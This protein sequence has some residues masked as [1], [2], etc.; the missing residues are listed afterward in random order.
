MR[1]TNLENV[2]SV[3]EARVANSKN[4]HQLVIL[5]MERSGPDSSNLWD[6]ND[7]KEILEALEP[8]HV[9]LRHLTV[10][11]YGGFKFPSWLGDP[12]FSKLVE[13]ELIGCRKCKLLTSF[14]QLRSLKKLVIVE[15]QQL[16][17]VSREFVGNRAFPSLQILQLKHLLNLEWQFE[18]KEVDFHECENL[19]GQDSEVGYCNEVIMLKSLSNLTSLSSL[20]ISGFRRVKLLPNGF[21]QSLIN[22]KD[23]EIENCNELLSLPEGPSTTL[24]GLHIINCPNMTSLGKGIQNMTCLKSKTTLSSVLPHLSTLEHLAI[25][26]INGLQYLPHDLL[27]NLTTL[28]ILDIDHCT[29]LASLPDYLP[30]SLAELRII[31]CAELASLPDELPSSLEEFSVYYCDKIQSL[32]KGLCNLTSLEYLWIECCP[33]V[34]SLPEDRLPIGLRSLLIVGCPTLSQWCKQ[35]GSKEWSMIKCLPNVHIRLE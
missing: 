22:I 16:K 21:L 2:E 28:K 6:G 8:P 11:N 12:S 30:S 14:G 17:H 9:N 19:S 29:K 13:I 31:H 34:E 23:M 7:E 10:K 3:E 20:N 25:K 18:A 24:S 32:P 15:M 1:I 33:L 5:V 26:E 27:L 35:Q 4:K